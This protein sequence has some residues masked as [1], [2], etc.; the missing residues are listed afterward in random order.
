M[1]R[2][3]IILVFFIF[4][5]CLVSLGYCLCYPVDSDMVVMGLG[6]LAFPVDPLLGHMGL[7]LMDP[8]IIE[9]CFG[10]PLQL[11]SGFSPMVLKLT[12]YSFYL[13]LVLVFSL[14]VYWIT[15]DHEKGLVAGALIANMGVAGVTLMSFVLYHNTTIILA[16]AYLILFYDFD[17]RKLWQKTCLLVLAFPIVY[18]DMMFAALFIIPYT[19]YKIIRYKKRPDIRVPVVLVSMAVASFFAKSIIGWYAGRSNTL[20][21]VAGLAGVFVRGLVYVDSFLGMLVICLVVLTVIW[22]MSGKRPSISFDD[23]TGYVVLMLSTSSVIMFAGFVLFQELAAARFLLIIALSIIVLAVLSFDKE[24]RLAKTIIIFSLVV[25]L[26]SNSILLIGYQYPAYTSDQQDV[27]GLIDVLKDR[28]LTYGY[29]NF[30]NSNKLTYL[31]G[32][33][34]RILGV[35]PGG[36]SLHLNNWLNEQKWY[37]DRGC[38]ILIRDSDNSSMPMISYP[39]DETIRY[40]DYNIHVYNESIKIVL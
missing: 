17:E 19:F 32:G 40:K 26:L 18:S 34:V 39:A 3:N 8:N 31:S 2:Y 28:G 25:A 5:G 16:I 1:S 36:D 38:F 10:V 35:S 37:T 9:L 13:G 20:N 24:N 33:E 30:I 4:L 29:A 21:L 11:L 22:L 15:R 27:Q 23:K 14:L 12:G 7:P 6:A